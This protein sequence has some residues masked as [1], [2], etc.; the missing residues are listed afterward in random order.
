MAKI[1][2]VEDNDTIR[3]AVTAYLSLEEHEVLEFSGI[4]G[5]LESITNNPPDIFILDIMLPDGNGFKLAREIRKK[6]DT[7]IIF[8]TAKI[9]ETDRITG[10]EIGG[11][12]YIVKPFSPRELVLR[13]KAILR[14]TTGKRDTVKQGTWTYNGKSLHIQL[15]S[16]K[17]LLNNKEIILTSAEW[18]ILMY[19]AQNEGIVIT[20]DTLLA[21]SLHYLEGST[22]RTIDTH[23]KNIR[24]KFKDAGW[25]ETVRGYGYKFTGV[26]V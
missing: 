25:I 26:S 2:I 16:H 22:T 15:D 19:L 5:V 10:F 20:R 17:V 8:L 1:I 3:E 14:R 7:P 4:A 18:E 13:V 9:S 21:N 11:D 23:I 24:I 6:Y 12:D